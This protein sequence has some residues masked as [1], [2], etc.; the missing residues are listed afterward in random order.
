MTGPSSP[1]TCPH[2]QAANPLDLGAKCVRCRKRMPA[3]CFACYAAIVD[4]KVSSCL[5]CG[6]RRWVVGDHADLA[7]VAEASHVRNQRYMATVFTG[8]KVVHVWRCM[9]CLLDET[10]TD[11]F[12]HFPDQVTATA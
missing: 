12:T 5:S 6:R 10:H 1:R 4:E 9:K 3:Y 7:C 2:C 11:A 8:G